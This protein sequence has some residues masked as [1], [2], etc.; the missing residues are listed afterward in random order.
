MTLASEPRLR[1]V[2]CSSLLATALSFAPKL[3]HAEDAEMRSA[4]RDL[5]TQGAQA[6]EA[7]QFA[8][9]SDFFRRAH[10]L[11]PAPSIALLQARSLSKL[12]NLVEAIDVYEQT[13]RLKL[14]GDA[15]EAYS[16][17]VQTAHIEVE[18]VR[19]RVS[20]LKLTLQGVAKGEALQVTIDEKPMPAVLL[21]VERPI[22]PGAHHI[23]VTVDGQARAARDFTVVEAGSELVV[24]DVSSAHPAKIAVVF[25]PLPVEVAASNGSSQR[26]LGFAA[27]GLGV[28]GLGLGTY[29]GLVAM[30]RKSDL[31]A[32]CSPTCPTSSAGDIDSFR[33]NRTVS[34]I[35]YGVG[36]AAVGV[37]VVLLVIGKP[38]QEHVALRA[39][40]NGLQIAGRL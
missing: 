34:W 20:R 26:T 6:F 4:A 8:Q 36:V 13:A 2:V 7:G 12:G 38:T 17:A 24:L 21:G 18:E 23:A 3:A 27:L 14:A 31:D 40:P 25:K 33:S 39:A 10:E 37:G 16:E 19:R 22:N 28:V 11:V 32:K 1:R 35:S 30:H 5:A 15:P 29:T 9:A